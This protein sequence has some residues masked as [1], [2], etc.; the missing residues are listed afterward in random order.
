MRQRDP[1]RALESVEDEARLHVTD[2][3]ELQQLLQDQRA[4]GFEVRGDD[5]KH[6]IVSAGG[7]E[8]SHHFGERFE[9]AM[10]LFD[11]LVGVTLEPHLDESLHGEPETRRIDERGVALNYATLLELADATSA[12]RM[13]QPADLCQLDH[14]APAV[15]L[16]LRQ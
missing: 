15:L 3:G 6:E 1:R 12:G 7:R 5:L 11:V 16:Q 9:R 14:R 10:E 2:S 8:A 13:G 4:E